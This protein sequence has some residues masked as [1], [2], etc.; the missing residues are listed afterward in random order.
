[1]AQVIR[2]RAFISESLKQYVVIQETVVLI[3]FKVHLVG[4][5]VKLKHECHSMI[6][7]TGLPTEYIYFDLHNRIQ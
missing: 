7:G 6:H 4:T 5:Y 2:I 1:M 3:E